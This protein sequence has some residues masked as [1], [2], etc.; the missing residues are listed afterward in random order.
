M[1]VLRSSEGAAAFDDDDAASASERDARTSRRAILKADVAR[2]AVAYVMLTAVFWAVGRLIL[3]SSWITDAD[4][5]I[6]ERFAARRTPGWNTVSYLGSQA[7][8]TAVKIVVTTVVCLVLYWM[9][10]RSRE[11]LMLVVPL[12]LEASVFI[13]VT[14]LVGRPRPNVERLESSPVNSSFPSGHV[15]AATVYGAL[16]IVVFRHTRNVWARTTVLIGCAVL[17]VLVGWAR[18][19]RGM[20]HLSDVIAGVALG[21]ASLSCAYV[22]V[23]RHEEATSGQRTSEGQP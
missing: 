7:A 14:L 10:R 19:Y 8:D 12:V 2:F 23:R 1:T 15:A 6:A 20:H 17:P 16:V 5:R 22:I 4:Q 9:W 3:A 18:M 11:P 13:T 21:I